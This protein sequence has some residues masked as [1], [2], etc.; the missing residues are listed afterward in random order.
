ML[1]WCHWIGWRADWWCQRVLCRLAQTTPG[2]ALPSP[3]LESII[4]IKSDSGLALPMPFVHLLI[5]LHSPHSLRSPTL[6]SSTPPHLNCGLFFFFEI[7]PFSLGLKVFWSLRSCSLSVGT[8]QRS[9]EIDISLVSRRGT[10]SFCFRLLRALGLYVWLYKLD[11]SI[12]PVNTILFVLTHDFFFPGKKKLGQGG[13]CV[14]GG[15]GDKKDE[16][17]ISK[18]T[19]FILKNHF[20]VLTPIWDGEIPS[21]FQRLKSSERKETVKTLAG[22]SWGFKTKTKRTLPFCPFNGHTCLEAIYYSPISFN[23][24]LYLKCTYLQRLKKITNSYLHHCLIGKLKLF[25]FSF[26]KPLFYQWEYS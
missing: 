12:Q 21:G 19:F 10:S 9:Q 7:P 22:I 5:I 2:E 18:L 8:H 23:T 1:G 6:V 15:E 11:H 16:Y 14:P 4:N 3:E 26:K 25:F 17:E 13:E 24:T 20:K